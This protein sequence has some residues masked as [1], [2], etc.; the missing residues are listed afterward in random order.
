[1]KHT[2]EHKV[3]AALEHPL[4]QH[5]T[6]NRGA[7]ENNCKW[8][9]KEKKCI[10]II[11][12]YKS[13]QFGLLQC[14]KLFEWIL[15]NSSVQFRYLKGRWWWYVC[16]V[17]WH[18]YLKYLLLIVELLLIFKIWVSYRIVKSYFWNDGV[19]WLS[20]QMIVHAYI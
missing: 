4:G 3:A 7:Q 17:V 8:F 20:I 5:K 1:M 16:Y 10:E 2:I 18:T 12:I 13:F 6:A 19:I 15:H 9:G 11:L 14:R